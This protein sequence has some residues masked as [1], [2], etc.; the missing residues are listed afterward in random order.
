MS[1]V[2]I[3]VAAFAILPACRAVVAEGGDYTFA[4]SNERGDAKKTS[5]ADRELTPLLRAVADATEEAIYNSILRATTVRGRDG[6]VAHAID[7]ERVRRAFATDAAR[8]EGGG[9]EGGER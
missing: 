4:F 1:R 8:R 6:H 9:D 5:L 2:A 3:L 7:V